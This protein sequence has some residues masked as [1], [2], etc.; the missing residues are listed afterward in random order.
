[1]KFSAHKK[2]FTFA[3]L[4]ERPCMCRKNCTEKISV[5]KKWQIWALVRSYSSFLN[6]VSAGGSLETVSG[7]TERPAPESKE[8][9]ASKGRWIGE[10]GSPAQDLEPL[11][12]GLTRGGW[13]GLRRRQHPDADLCCETNSVLK[14]TLMMAY[15]GP[16]VRGVP[17]K[18]IAL[19][20][21]F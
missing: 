13:G 19:M 3:I 20:N 1:M 8:F 9:D 17:G 4:S 21:P 12:R 5:E 6:L 7:V 15:D 11:W 18:V 16:V 14:E 10:R 2:R